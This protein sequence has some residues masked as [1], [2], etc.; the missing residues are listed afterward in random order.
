VKKPIPIHVHLPESERG[1]YHIAALAREMQKTGA[2]SFWLDADGVENALENT[3]FEEKTLPDDFSKSF[4]LFAAEKN[5]KK[6]EILLKHIE[7]LPEGHTPGFLL[8]VAISP[9]QAERLLERIESLKRHGIGVCLVSERFLSLPE[10]EAFQFLMESEQAIKLLDSKGVK[11]VSVF[12][13][14]KNLAVA[15]NACRHIKEHTGARVVVSF[16]PCKN[17]KNC[18]IRNAISLGSV[19]SESIA[20]EVLVF[21]QSGEQLFPA[22]SEVKMVLSSCQVSPRGYTIISCPMCG[23]C[24]LD[25][26]TLTRAIEKRLAALE[27]HYFDAGRRLEDIGGITVAV[28]GCIVNGPGEAREADIGVAGAKKNRGVLFME[29]KPFKTVTQEQI[30]DELL[31]HTKALVDERFKNT[32]GLKFR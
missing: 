8:G 10:Q 30:V 32:K 1:A 11:E 27:K 13:A 4:R 17:E 6:L 12:F 19:F 21:P 2:Q 16:S 20:D 3:V 31:S 24:M 28:M 14:H 29:G 9:R 18:L 5:E 26:E 25:I 23:R 22:V 15:F 7:A